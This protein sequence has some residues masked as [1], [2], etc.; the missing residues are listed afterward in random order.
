[1]MRE[2]QKELKI[3]LILAQHLNL[4][5]TKDIKTFAVK[6]GEKPKKNTKVL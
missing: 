2:G 1:M 3:R 4:K 5:G 6:P